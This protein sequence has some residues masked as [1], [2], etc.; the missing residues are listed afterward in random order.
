MQ[1]DDATNDLILDVLPDENPYVKLRDLLIRD[2][3]L[4]IPGVKVVSNTSKA[5]ELAG[6][7]TA[8]K[9]ALAQD[10]QNHHEYE[11]SLPPPDKD[12]IKAKLLILT[13]GI[14]EAYGEFGKLGKK[15]EDAEERIPMP[16]PLSR[17]QCEDMG[18]VR[19]IFSGITDVSTLP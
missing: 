5:A 10:T 16:L 3:L 9:N 8:F 12:D 13:L 17:K 18:L 11:V 14:Q 19:K 2:K 6:I 1:D 15:G 7:R 4:P